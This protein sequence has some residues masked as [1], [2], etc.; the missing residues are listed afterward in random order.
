MSSAGE[1]KD[2]VIHVDF[3]HRTR[4][5]PPA[6]AADKPHQDF[7]AGGAAA[8]VRDVLLSAA[9][10]GRIERGRAYFQNG[11]L[12]S[13]LIREGLILAKVSGSEDYPFEAKIE[14]PRRPAAVIIGAIR[15]LTSQDDI[16]EVSE[17]AFRALLADHSAQL[18]FSCSCPDS[19]TV[20][21]HL[22]ALGYGFADIIAGNPYYLL[23]LRGHGPSRLL[24]KTRADEH[25][26]LTE[27]IERSDRG[28][29]ESTRTR[30]EGTPPRA[31]SVDSNGR[32]SDAAAPRDTSNDATQET[33]S[34][35]HQDFWNGGVLPPLPHPQ[36]A[37]A[38]D[39]GDDVILH[40]ALR[41]LSLT[42][43]DMLRAKSDLEDIYTILISDGADRGDGIDGHSSGIFTDAEPDGVAADNVESGGIAADAAAPPRNTAFDAP[44]E[45]LM[46]EYYPDDL[47]EEIEDFLPDDDF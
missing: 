33:Q 31:E 32:P 9:D 7:S 39:D 27:V 8:I 28:S 3:A 29:D 40:Q 37:P 15:E 30:Q 4:T 34:R 45:E 22:V 13:V 47:G 12:E 18:R 21:K 42:S 26:A 41:A 17:T 35:G 46:A 5:S 44:D 16:A 25:Y 38:V 11:H 19:A 23:A 6:A 1:S 2:N 36:T 20:C 43:I 24:R 14:F 10:P